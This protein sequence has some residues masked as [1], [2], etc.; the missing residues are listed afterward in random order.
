MIVLH[1][2]VAWRENVNPALLKISLK[3]VQ[4]YLFLPVWEEKVYVIAQTISA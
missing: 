4:S 1:G 3:R 2:Y